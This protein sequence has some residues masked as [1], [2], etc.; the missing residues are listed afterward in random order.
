MPAA[1][2]R[3]YTIDNFYVSYFANTKKKTKKIYNISMQFVVQNFLGTKSRRLHVQ[4]Y[5][6]QSNS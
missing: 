4:D 5:L 3:P 6:L 2:C 1:Q